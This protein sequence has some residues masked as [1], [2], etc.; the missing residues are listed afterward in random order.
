M[1]TDIHTMDGLKALA[2]RC[3]DD[4]RT[5]AEAADLFMKELRSEP[6]LI[7]LLVEPQLPHIAGNYL[8]RMR[9]TWQAGRRS[10]AVWTKDD[11]TNDEIGPAEAGAGGGGQR[12]H[13][14]RVGLAPVAS[15]TFGPQGSASGVDAVETGGAIFPSAP[16]HRAPRPT[17]TETPA[18][19]GG[20][21]QGVDDTHVELASPH[22]IGGDADADEAARL[23]TAPTEASPL[24][25][26][27]NTIGGHH[28]SDTLRRPAAA[29]P[30]P[31]EHPAPTAAVAPINEIA[32]MSGDVDGVGQRD[33][34]THHGFAHPSASLPVQPS[35]PEPITGSR[36]Y[37]FGREVLGNSAGGMITN[38]IRHFGG[39]L[40]QA[41]DSLQRAAQMSEPRAYIG[42]IL[43]GASQGQGKSGGHSAGDTHQFGAAGHPIH[44]TPRETVAASGQH[45]EDTQIRAAARPNSETPPVNR[46]AG[47]G[48]R[49]YDTLS[50]AASPSPIPA[51]NGRGRDQATSGSQEPPVASKVPAKAGGAGRFNNGHH[52]QVAR[53]AINPGRSK[54][55]NPAAMRLV[56][57]AVSRSILDT[58][59][60][61]D[62]LPLRKATV[63]QADA[64][65]NRRNRETAFIKLVVHGIP[66]G[67]VI[68]DFI[69]DKDAAA[70]WK[71]TEDLRPI[72]AP[73]IEA[74]H[75]ADY[76]EITNAV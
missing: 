61:A 52:G 65:A 17:N 15:N 53:P 6:A 27:P 32:G 56:S 75:P 36:V 12:R 67:G 13:D 68:G 10:V 4:G 31:A 23:V 60:L 8:A 48:H 74:R 5:E 16:I 62:G 44:E 7:A 72:A 41:L 37:A 18:M 38:L 57:A 50:C 70:L 28:D 14:N 73:V 58:I 54:P 22:S 33:H 29:P 45:L 49:M 76:R 47:G 20:G 63:E 42:K 30:Q 24:S 25:S 51:S 1:N 21:G 64:Y 39:G 59:T 69:T 43:T 9:V 35:P 46:A 26:A 34:D 19:P 71:R 11:I 66:H 2:F 40:N 55:L 3:L